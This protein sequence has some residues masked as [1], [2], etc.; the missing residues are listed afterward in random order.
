MGR[1][2]RLPPEKMEDL[3][4]RGRRKLARFSTKTIVSLVGRGFPRGK[5][6][7]ESVFLRKYF[8]LDPLRAVP[9]ILLA[10]FMP[11]AVINGLRR[12]KRRRLGQPDDDIS[13]GIP[14]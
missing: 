11:R 3:R 9:A 2:K 12:W 5:V 4:E 7:R 14:G 8:A 1:E 6:L 10:A 13:L